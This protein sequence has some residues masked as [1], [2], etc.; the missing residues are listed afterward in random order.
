MLGSDQQRA[1]RQAATAAIHATAQQLRPTAASSDDV[2][3]AEHL[4]RIIDEV[5]QQPPT[6]T[7][8]LVEHATLLEGLRAGVGARLAVLDDPHIT[9]TGHSSVEL[10]GVAASVVTEI[11]TTHL[12]QEIVI[13]GASGGPLNLTPDVLVPKSLAVA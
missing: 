2:V 6:P 5:F 10:L 11:L 1:L 7:E 3:G 8:S 9:G 12:L 4:A 13:R